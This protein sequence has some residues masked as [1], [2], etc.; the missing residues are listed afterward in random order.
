[1][2]Y[3]GDPRR[4]RTNKIVSSPSKHSPASTSTLTPNS[5]TPLTPHF[6][7]PIDFQ[8]ISPVSH[9]PTPAPFFDD[10]S[11]QVAHHYGFNTFEELHDLQ[12]PGG[13]HVDFPSTT[14]IEGRG[15]WDQPK[16]GSSHLW[17]FD[18]LVGHID[19]DCS[20]YNPPHSAVTLPSQNGDLVRPAATQLSP[21]SQPTE[22][23]SELRGGRGS[24]YW[25]NGMSPQSSAKNSF[26]AHDI[27]QWPGEARFS[28]PM[29]GMHG[30]MSL[31]HLSIE[32][33]ERVQESVY[34]ISLNQ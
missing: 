9:P 13:S 14:A 16:Q 34:T 27:Q 33:V 25:S 24:G 21:T 5:D 31:P 18:T 1:M 26:T 11:I 22:E 8:T 28:E 23:R 12:L 15:F 2:D 10:H 7:Q 29:Q 32:A 6:G 4:Y 19:G 20:Y 30:R 3:E 17:S